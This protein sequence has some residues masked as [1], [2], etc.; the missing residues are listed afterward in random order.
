VTSTS[1][2]HTR[3]EALIRRGEAI[4]PVPGM[5]LIPTKRLREKRHSGTRGTPYSQSRAC[6]SKS[7]EDGTSWFPAKRSP[8]SSPELRNRRHDMN[9]PIP[10]FVLRDFA[11]RS[12]NPRGMMPSYAYR[13]WT[14]NVSADVDTGRAK[15]TQTASER[16]PAG[17]TIR[18]YETSPELASNAL[19]S[20]DR[21][22]SRWVTSG[23]F[24]R[25]ELGRTPTVAVILRNGLGRVL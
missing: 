12:A 5:S 7:G 21:A 8:R 22:H 1:R 9:N 13:W 10:D 18:V 25:A 20:W 19:A 24:P 17:E 23:F 2:E 3:R 4:L 15:P 11:E 16:P 14:P 6:S